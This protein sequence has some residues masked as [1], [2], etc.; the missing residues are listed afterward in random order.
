MSFI[1]NIIFIIICIIFL[2]YIVF[3]YFLNEYRKKYFQEYK[4]SC[5][6][7]INKQQKVIYDLMKEL[8]EDED[9][10]DIMIQVENYK[11]KMEK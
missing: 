9:F 3:N 4:D 8:Y 1:M 6:E 7:L 11:E 10:N 2:I 5:D